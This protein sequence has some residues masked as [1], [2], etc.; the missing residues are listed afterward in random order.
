M[1]IL[2]SQQIHLPNTGGVVSSDAFALS[3]ASDF[4]YSSDF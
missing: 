3:V 4:D 2:Q 1:A